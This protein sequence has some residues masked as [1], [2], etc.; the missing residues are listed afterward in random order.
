MT[1]LVLS[2][3]RD[4]DFGE[5]AGV[6]SPI[7]GRAANLAAATALALADPEDSDANSLFA[8]VKLHDELVSEGEDVAIATVCGDRRV[9]P[10]SDRRIARDLDHVIAATKADRAILVTDGAEDEYLLPVV[11]SRVR[12]DAVRRVI[13]KQAADL[14]STYYIIK[15]AL[16]DEKLQR[17]LVMPI[18]LGLFMYGIFAVTGNAEKGFGAI[19]M[20]VGVY[21]LVKVS[22]MVA[23]ARRLLADTYAGLTGGR[24]TLFAG[25]L[26]ILVLLLGAILSARM[27]YEL[28]DQVVWSL[29]AVRAIEG[30]APFAVAA[31]L[32]AIGGKV[33]D[34]Y[35]RER[36]VLW[37][38]LTLPFSVV[39]VGL[40][41][42]ASLAVSENALLGVDN[43]VGLD[44]LAALAAGFGFALIGAVTNAYVKERHPSAVRAERPG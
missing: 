37:N 29:L 12:V 31:S 21:F 15:K 25:I 16:D 5:K 20:T 44:E 14:E 11:T 36:V 42:H 43:A 10:V 24:I 6:A 2:I 32:I 35:V 1:L 19:A 28:R 7:V 40:I 18:A 17:T 39:A 26:A 22:H 38:Y 8:A 41:L 34:V 9:G 23:V 4:N 13:V 27:I 33:A 3:D 30:L